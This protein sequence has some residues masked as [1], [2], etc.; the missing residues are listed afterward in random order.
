MG[1]F[2]TVCSICGVP[3]HSYIFKYLDENENV[4]EKE[5][6][7]IQQKVKWVSKCVLLLENGV[8]K[9][10]MVEVGGNGI[11]IPNNN[12]KDYNYVVHH[13]IPYKHNKPIR[14]DFHFGIVLHED[15][16]KFINK[17]YGINLQLRHFPVHLLS[18]DQEFAFPTINYGSIEKYWGQFFDFTKLSKNKK[19]MEL[20]LSPL[21]SKTKQAQ[22]IKIFNQF[23]IRADRKSPL[24]SASFYKENTIKYGEDKKLWIIKNGK[25]IKLTDDKI[26]KASY[27]YKFNKLNDKKLSTILDNINMIPRIDESSKNIIARNINLNLRKK[28]LELDVIGNNLDKIQKLFDK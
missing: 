26:K 21:V 27:S 1:Y 9:H 11:F 4:I 17:K 15:C 24:I 20:I 23:K 8:L 10:N 6:K 25:W 7:M 22:I 16:H 28:I 5:T 19:D 18:Y 14:K 3:F 13:R 12:K 2:D